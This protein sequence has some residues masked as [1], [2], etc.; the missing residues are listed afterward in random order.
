MVCSN[1]I[2]RFPNTSNAPDRNSRASPVR[3]RLRCGVRSSH[4]HARDSPNLMPLLQGSEASW[5]LAEQFDC[6]PRLHQLRVLAIC[7]NGQSL[8]FL[9]F[10]DSRHVTDSRGL[11]GRCCSWSDRTVVSR[12]RN[13]NDSFFQRTVVFRIDAS[14]IAGITSSKVD[15]QQRPS[16]SFRNGLRSRVPC[17]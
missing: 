1:P 9:A 2:G 6:N 17:S 15:T 5:I 11:G 14:V 3:P 7:Q 8:A 13:H 12:V 16:L 4:A 10:A